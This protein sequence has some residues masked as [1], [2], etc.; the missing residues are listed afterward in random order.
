MLSV[1]SP[2]PRFLLAAR[3]AGVAARVGFE[4]VS[5]GRFPT[6]RREQAHAKGRQRRRSPAPASEPGSKVVEEIEAG[7]GKM[8]GEKAKPEDQRR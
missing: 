1:A 2:P 3:I 7:R 4:I 8:G 5:K 6:W